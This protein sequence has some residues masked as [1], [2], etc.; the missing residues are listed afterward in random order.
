MTLFKRSSTP[1]DPRDT[2]I[3]GVV[4]GK[5]FADVGG[6]WGLVNE[7]VSVANSAGARSL[8]MIDRITPKES[9]WAHFR[10]RCRDLG[11]G[12]VHHVSGD[13]IGVGEAAQHPVFDVVHCGG[14]L[15]HA[16]DPVRLLRALR[17]I[18]TEHLVLGTLVTASRV[19][20]DAGMM[21][22]PDSGA[23]FIPALARRERTI[24]ESYWRQFVGDGAVGL[25]S[26]TAWDPD[27]YVPWW[28]LP[29]ETALRAMC[30]VAGFTCVDAS[31]YWNNNAIA[32]LLAIKA[33]R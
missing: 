11:V 13:I 24:L 7:K 33:A 3:A 25:T 19:E 4:K 1:A 2:F 6:L 26:P 22:V 16:P 17:R 14:V 23:L 28:W 9:L 12:E 20:T 21:T 5:S 32:L 8:T 15:Y 29:T 30:E 31:Y 27:N 10:E 18:T